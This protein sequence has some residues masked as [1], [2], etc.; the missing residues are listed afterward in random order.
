MDLTYML[1][2]QGEH[3]PHPKN[4]TGDDPTHPEGDEDAV[5]ERSPTPTRTPS[6]NPMK[7]VPATPDANPIDPRVGQPW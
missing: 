4:P 1:F 2:L 3:D 5:T 7:P 6:P